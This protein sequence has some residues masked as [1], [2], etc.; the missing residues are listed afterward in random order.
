VIDAGIGG[1]EKDTVDF[2]GGGER[3]GERGDAG[4]T[5]KRD[6]DNEDDAGAELIGDDDE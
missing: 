2:N 1:G 6:S 5:N 4:A 3:G